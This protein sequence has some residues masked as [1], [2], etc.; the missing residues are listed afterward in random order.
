MKRP[1]FV[2]QFQDDIGRIP[3]QIRS[4]VNVNR[5]L[6]EDK[7]M[8]ALLAPV[9]HG[10][11]NPVPA[12]DTQVSHYHDMLEVYEGIGTASLHKKEVAY[13]ILAGG[14]GTRVGGPKALLHIPELNMSLLTLKLHQAVGQGPIWILVSPTIR[15]E[16]EAHVAEQK[17][18]DQAR[19]KFVEQFESYRLT[20]HNQLVFDGDVPSIY[21]CGH[22]DLFPALAGSAVWRD[23]IESGGKHVVVVNV[24]NVFGSLEPAILGHHI[25]NK[26]KVTCEVVRRKNE[27]LG[28]VLVD[29]DEGLQ[30]VE[31]FRLGVPDA[32][33]YS[34]LST[35]SYIFNT[36]LQI[37]K[38]GVTWHR[39]QKLLDG[40]VVI[41]HERLMQEITAAYNSTFLGVD[42]TER[43]MPIRDQMD[44]SIVR[45]ISDNSWNR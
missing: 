19:I 32:D 8:E 25:D 23:F 45:R 21:P 12:K 1:G 36:D 3:Q 2:K 30:I 31:L 29:C 9:D 42:R 16:V 20:P 33:A 13:C 22:G 34:W 24:D 37:D 14:A 10:V 28:G 43:Y 44:L 40:R 4:R 18:I 38:L 27:E 26:S 6:S 15:A 39:K 17:D 35:N 7:L 41:Q 11:T 5:G